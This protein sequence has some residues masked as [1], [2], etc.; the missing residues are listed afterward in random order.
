MIQEYIQKLVEGNSL[1]FNES[2][3]IMHEIITGK[4]TNAQTGALLTALR[5][6]GE[7]TEELFAFANVMKNHCLQIKPHVQGKLVDTC[8]TGGDRVKTFNVSTTAAFVI[9][10]AGIPVAKHGNRAVTSK[11]GSADVLERLGLNLAMSPNDVQEAIEKV[12]IGFM[13]A[14]AFHPAMRFATQ[15]RKEMGIRTVF[16]LLGPLT[17]PANATG[18]L[19][20]VYDLKLVMPIAEVLDKLGCREAM[21]VHGLDG[22]DEISTLGKTCIVHLKHGQIHQLDV[23]PEFFGVKQVEASNLK[24]SNVDDSAKT[25][26]TI[27]KGKNLKNPKTEMV[28]VNSAAGIIVGGKADDFTEAMQIARESILSGAAYD[29]LK[30]LIR[31]SGGNLQT[32]EELETQYE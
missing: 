17:N 1:S 2:T 12:G 25:I 31:V 24:V 21:V 27:L 10:G 29:K 4:T 26:Q 19:L 22:L 15:P 13:F 30:E 14:P 7:S 16:N 5:I 6:K 3:Q 32:L 20:G 18:Q 23:S 9:A 8:G 11:S 28:L